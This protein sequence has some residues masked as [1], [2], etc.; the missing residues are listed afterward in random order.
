MEKRNLKQ[1]EIISSYL[2]AGPKRCT[3]ELGTGFGKSK[4]A[5]E[6]VR[7]LEPENVLILVNSVHLKDYSWRKEFLQWD[8]LDYFDKHVDIVTYQTA[9]KYKK[10]INKLDGWFIIADEV[11]FA[12]NVPEYSKFFYEYPDNTVLGLTGFITDTKK[13]WF[14]QHLPVFESLSASTAQSEGILNQLHFVFVKFDLSRNPNDLEVEYKKNGI[15]SH[16]KQ[17][18]NNAYGYLDSKLSQC[19]AASA[20][21]RQSCLLGEI[22]QDDRDR[23]LSKLQYDIEMT[24]RKRADLLVNGI[25]S[26][27]L[28]KNLR[29]HII[30]SNPST[31]VIIFSKRTNQSNKI[32]G[33]SHVYNGSINKK[34]AQKNYEEFLDG[35]K[36]YLGVVDKINRG[37]NI[38]GLKHAIFESFF[39][40]DVESTQRFGRL[41]RLDPGDMAYVYILLPY[42]MKEG[43]DKTWNVTETQQVKWAREML[44]STKVKNHSIWDYRAVKSD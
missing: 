28:A 12:A 11:D 39:S 20:S 4:V 9:Y 7:W 35:T 40:S 30:T 33:K 16:F 2:R 27:E 5:I 8:M 36:N 23:K 10:N 18:E 1:E 43:P 3:L 38:P 34:A 25:A 31:K 22:T 15:T 14:E 21:A 19:I 29:D 44:R 6:I 32:C 17:S 24:T 13:E 42:Y 26:A 37:A 41:L